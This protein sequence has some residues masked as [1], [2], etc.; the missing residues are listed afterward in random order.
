VE[1]ATNERLS[2]IESYNAIK[3]IKKQL[4]IDFAKIRVAFLDQGSKGFE[5]NTFAESVAA[6]RGL[7]LRFFRYKEE[8]LDWLQKPA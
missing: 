4:G 1:G 3:S 8:A 2:L 5:H 6:N 7:Y